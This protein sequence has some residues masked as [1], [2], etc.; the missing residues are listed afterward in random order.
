MKGFQW[1]LLL[2][3][4]YFCTGVIISVSIS[5][6]KNTILKEQGLFLEIGFGCFVLGCIALRLAVYFQYFIITAFVL[7]GIYTSGITLIGSELAVY[8]QNDYPTIPQLENEGIEE[9][10]GQYRGQMAIY[11]GCGVLLLTFILIQFNVLVFIQK[12]LSFLYYNNTQQVQSSSPPPPTT[13]TTKHNNSIIIQEDIQNIA[14]KSGILVILLSGLCLIILDDKEWDS[15]YALIIFSTLIISVYLNVIS[16]WANNIIDITSNHEDSEC[17]ITTSTLSLFILLNQPPSSITKMNPRNQMNAFHL[18]F[19]L[20]ALIVLQ[21][22]LFAEN[23][24]F[25][26]LME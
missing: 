16:K 6:V 13:T 22:L 4:I 23:W 1:V 18:A 10:D 24:I 9:N 26:C 2:Q 25:I 14:I 12:Y 8:L 3:A 15:R 5:D 7:F 17:P 20:A 11:I 21:P 19:H